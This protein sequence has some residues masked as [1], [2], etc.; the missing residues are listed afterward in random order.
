MMS[1][2]VQGCPPIHL[3]NKIINNIGIMQG[4]LT[5]PYKNI[6]QSFPWKN[7]KNELEIAKNNNFKFIE[8]TIDNKD[9]NKNPLIKNPAF[10]KQFI[11]E[12][13]INIHTITADSVMQKPLHKIKKHEFEKEFNSLQSLI[14]S[15]SLIGIKYII[16]PLVDNGSIKTQRQENFLIEILEKLYEK[17]NKEKMIILF[18]SDYNPL[19]LKKFIEKLPR[20]SFGINYDTGN[21][22]HFGYD[23][24]DEFSS[25]ANRVMNI[26]I[27][28]RKYNGPSIPL[29]EG[30]VDFNILF[31]LIHSYKYN[32]LLILQTAR[33]K[34]GEELKTIIRYRDFLLKFL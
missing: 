21:S 27:K 15:S 20:T 33:K 12:K 6:I 30:D 32:K 28:D 11:E 4:R 8:W 10:V 3:K 25:Y 18:E 5:R 22:A 9:F 19:K 29:G 23:I 16:Y 13:K 26:H 24:K 17:L 31:N 2:K 14:S 7:W 34:I 1:N